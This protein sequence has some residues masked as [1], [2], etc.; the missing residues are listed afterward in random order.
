LCSI[1]WSSA[2][3]SSVASA[4]RQ[5]SALPVYEWG[6]EEAAAG[7]VVVE[8]GVDLVG[9]HDDR[10]RQIAPRD[11]FREAQE[12]RLDGRLLMGEKGAGAAAADGDLVTDQMH[13]VLVAEAA[14]ETQVF[15]IVHRHAAGALDQRFDDQR[16]DVAM[17]LFEMAFKVAGR[18]AGHVDPALALCRKA[19]IG[20]GDGMGRTNQ[21]AIGILEQRHVGYRQG[22]DGLAVITAGKAEEVLFFHPTPVLPGVER[23]LERDLGRRCAHRKHRSS[24]RACPR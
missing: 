3:M 23:H 16:C 24:G 4:A 7:R 9:R 21:R 12:V 11:A 5:A 1:T 6:M 10:Q 22:A 17:V 18:P 14:G 2:K 13:L 15:R 20:R 8:L 19:R